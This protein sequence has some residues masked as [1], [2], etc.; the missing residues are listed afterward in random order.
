MQQTQITA[1]VCN[2]LLKLAKIRHFLTRFA[3]MLKYGLGDKYF[4]QGWSD[5]LFYGCLAG[6][7]VYTDLALAQ[8]KYWKMIWIENQKY[9]FFTT[10]FRFLIRWWEAEIHWNCEAQN[11]LSGYLSKNFPSPKLKTNWIR[12]GQKGIKH[13]NSAKVTQGASC[14]VFFE[15]EWTWLRERFGPDSWSCLFRIGESTLD[16]AIWL[17]WGFCNIN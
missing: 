10:L 8:K 3:K 6:S 12:D 16:P 2:L 15:H 17:L 5:L 11:F 4:L 14:V 7:I 9:R 13:P 1:F